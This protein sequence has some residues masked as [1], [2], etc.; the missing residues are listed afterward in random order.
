MVGKSMAST[1]SESKAFDNP[2]N[3]QNRDMVISHLSQMA[4]KIVAVWI[5]ARP[6]NWQNKSKFEHWSVIIRGE[7]ILILLDFLEHNNRGAFRLKAL[8][9][10][11][12]E[13]I[14][15]FKWKPPDE[16]QN[17]EKN[18]KIKPQKYRIVASVTPSPLMDKSYFGYVDEK[19]EKKLKKYIKE[20]KKHTANGDDVK[21]DENDDLCKV[22]KTDKN[23]TDIGDFVS[24][25][26]VLEEEKKKKKKDEKKKNL[27]NKPKAAKGKPYNWV[28][29][30]CQQFAVHLFEDI[31]GNAYK[32][33]VKYASEQTQS[34]ADINY[35]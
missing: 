26:S 5:V 21:Y 25:W 34:P 1:G 35:K 32:D 22:I 16:Q 17:D 2:L 33:K 23:V 29:H 14:E 30:N 7:Q 12:S 18:E 9:Y 3:G 19:E 4:D 10:S 11:D 24:R 27:Q 13:F 20:K 6:V 28:S 31:V 8:P 15:F